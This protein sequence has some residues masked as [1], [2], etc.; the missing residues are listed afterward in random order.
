MFKNNLLQ[1]FFALLI[2]TVVQSE[3]D[4]L[5]IDD[6]SKGIEGKFP[7]WYRWRDGWSMES[8]ENYNGIEKIYQIA[9]ENGNKF[10]KAEDSGK[11]ITIGKEVSWNLKKYPVFSW[12][13]RVHSIPPNANEKEGKN[14]S[15][16]G[17]YVIFKRNFFGVP[18]SIKYVWSSTLPVE[19]GFRKNK[20]GKPHV[21]VVETGEKNLNK[22]LLYE[23]NLIEDYKNAYGENPDDKILAIAILTDSNSTGAVSSA[24]YDD[25]LAFPAKRIESSEVKINK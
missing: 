22:W 14:D 24:D 4:Y 23:R 12:K 13:W 3:T 7:S 8:Y 5:V 9:N 11:S 16:A 10:L 1:L 6:F 21:I 15:A 19:T 25:L 18:K 20:A 2:F 17:I